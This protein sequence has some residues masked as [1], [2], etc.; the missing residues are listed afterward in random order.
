M[1]IM[2]TEI[3]CPDSCACSNV[4]DTPCT[5]CP[6]RKA[7]TPVKSYGKLMVLYICKIH[8]ISKRE[9][10]INN[11]LCGIAYRASVFLPMK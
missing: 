2:H 8:H 11:V 6:W 1:L 7:R 4:Q 5:V 9:Q 10:C 3:N